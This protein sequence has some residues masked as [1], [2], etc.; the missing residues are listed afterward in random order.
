MPARCA[1][2]EA[3]MA[4]KSPA[5]PQPKGPVRDAGTGRYVPKREAERRPKETVTESPKKK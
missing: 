1:E 5:K 2:K 3:G 4:K